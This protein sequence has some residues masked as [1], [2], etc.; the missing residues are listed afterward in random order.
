MVEDIEDAFRWVREQGPQLFRADLT[1]V[2]VAGG[3]AG[4]YLALVAGSR[5]RSALKGVVSC[6]GY[7]ELLDPW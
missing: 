7:G 6:W 5:V 1:R 3:S 4:G 2:A